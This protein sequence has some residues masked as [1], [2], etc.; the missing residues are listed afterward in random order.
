MQMS[1]SQNGAVKH[2]EPVAKS[3]ADG[4]LKKQGSKPL[5]EQSNKAKP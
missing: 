4:L 5:Q 1:L 2:V 3:L